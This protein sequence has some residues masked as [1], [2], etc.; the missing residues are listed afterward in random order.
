MRPRRSWC[1][2]TAALAVVL[3]AVVL[4]ACGGPGSASFRPEAWQPPPSPGLEDDYERN[5]RL[6]GAELWPV[7]GAGPEDVAVD[8]EGRLYT[9]LEDGRI[10]RLPAGGGAPEVLADTGG[11]PLGLELDPQGRLVI[12]DA[13]EGLLRLAPD[14]ELET[15]VDGFEGERFRFTNSAAV[16]ADGTIYFTDTS[17]RYGIAAYKQDLLEHSGTGRLFALRPDGALDLLVDGLQ[18]ANGVALDPEERWLLVAETG[19]YRIRRL[20]LTPDRP[21]QEEIFVDNLPG[22]PDNLSTGEGV[23]WLAMP[24]PRDR[25]LDALLPMPLLRHVVARLPDRLQPQPKRHGF[26]LGFDATGKVVHNL[27][28]PGGRVALTTGARE[29]GG[30]LYLGSLSEST[31]AVHSLP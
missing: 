18:F 15:L 9:G 2:T 24:S 27:Q 5:D 25:V 31:V 8:P 23:F 1:P 21:G 26:V 16:A 30:R 6:A 13:D 17:R 12:C 7:G 11:R 3:A 28:D 19:A 14:G 10:V 22:F 20:W 4:P 29:H